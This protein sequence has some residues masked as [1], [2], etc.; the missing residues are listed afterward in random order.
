MPDSPFCSLTS[1]APPD[2]TPQA[3]TRVPNPRTSSGPYDHVTTDSQL[4]QLVQRM[5][6]TNAKVIWASTTPIP[7]NPEQKQTAA[8]IVERNAAAAEVMQKHG[9]LRLAGGGAIVSPTLQGT[10]LAPRAVLAHRVWWVRG[11]ITSRQAK[12]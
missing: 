12:A 6:Q 9:A 8:S 4:E 7:D 2:P 10:N 11:F 5:K 1:L 3:I